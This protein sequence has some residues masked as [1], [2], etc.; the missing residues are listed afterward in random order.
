MHIPHD[1]IHK[2]TGS[3]S[4]LHQSRWLGYCLGSDILRWH[5]RADF[6][7]KSSVAS[8]IP[9]LDQQ[10]IFGPAY[11]WRGLRLG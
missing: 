2:L 8:G 5:Q 11:E 7:H 3:P 10:R 4:L 1:H 6:C 9:S